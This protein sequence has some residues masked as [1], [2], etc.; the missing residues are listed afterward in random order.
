MSERDS[1]RD[2]PP[3]QAPHSTSPGARPPRASLAGTVGYL[4]RTVG[5][6]AVGRLVDGALGSDGR[7]LP[8]DLR[9][10][11]EGLFGHDFS[12]VRV[13]VGR[14][15]RA[16]ARAVDAPA[17]AVGSHIVVGDERDLRSPEAI[18]AL[19]HE[20]AHVVQQPRDPVGPLTVGPRGD[21]A[22]READSAGRA[23]AA[24]LGPSAAVSA[25]L[26]RMPS[27]LA[28]RAGVRRFTDTHPRALRRAWR[29][30]L[31]E[32]PA[33]RISVRERSALGQIR[34][35]G[36]AQ[37]REELVI[38]PARLTDTPTFVAN[39]FEFFY[40]GLGTVPHSEDAANLASQMLWEAVQASRTMDLVPRPTGSPPGLFWLA[41][42]AVQM[43]FRRAMDEGIYV[44]VRNVV[45]ARHRSDFEML[46]A[47]IP[48]VH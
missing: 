33:A 41:K 34:R 6:R 11:M 38:D 36:R 25:A 14:E 9:A 18:P 16:A 42:E 23:A 5:N 13:H 45:A 3:E 37:P 8:P 10:P 47:G 39:I 21:A 19:A 4:Q 32:R 1:R 29:D 46:Q 24:A 17:F 15:A 31:E 35:M 44:S 28:V 2:H 27:R 22:E 7:A 30:A 48:L 26:T 12:G 40:P 43:A 20:L